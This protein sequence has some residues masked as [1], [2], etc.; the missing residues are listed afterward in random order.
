MADTTNLFIMIPTPSL[1]AAMIC[2]SDPRNDESTDLF[3]TKQNHFMAHQQ[4]NDTQ[5]DYNMI[6]TSAL[7]VGPEYY[8]TLRRSVR[9]CDLSLNPP[10]ISRRT[11][12]CDRNKIK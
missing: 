5:L 7:D 9:S 1:T 3:K 12:H 10:L 8:L 4:G 6:P 11:C 2:V